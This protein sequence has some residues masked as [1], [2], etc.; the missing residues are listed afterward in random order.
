V[1]RAQRR[2]ER[3]FVAMV[4]ADLSDEPLRIGGRGRQ[5]LR[6]LIDLERS[7]N[8]LLLVA[9]VEPLEEIL[10]QADQVG[11]AHTTLID[12]DARPLIGA[13]EVG[14]VLPE[15]MRRQAQ[16]QR[17]SS[18][19]GR[20]E[21]LGGEEIVAAFVP[22]EGTRWS[23]VSR[24]PRLAADAARRR[25]QLA[26]ASA[27]VGALFIATLLSVLGYRLLVRPI[28]RLVRAQAEVAGV[29]TLPGGSEIA[30]LESTFAQLLRVEQERDSIGEVF[31]GR[32]R[33]TGKLGRGGS[34]T[35]FKGFD[36]VLQRPVALK[37]VPL[38]NA[39]Q[40][41]ESVVSKLQAEAV[42]LARLNHPHIVTV[43][44]FERKG[45]TAYIAM[46][47][48][49]GVSLD[50]YLS[51][52]KSMP[53]R[54]GVGIA[55]AITAALVAAHGVN[56]VHG[57]LKPGNI[58]VGKDGAI[59]V[60]DFGTARLAGTNSSSGE[61]LHGTAGYLAP[62]VLMRHGATRVSDLFSLGVVIY[63]MFA[64]HRPFGGGSTFEI[65][66]RT[67]E[68]QPTDLAEIRAS[69]PRELTRL[70]MKLLAKDP[71]ERPNSAAMV[72]EVL[73]RLGSELGEDW[74]LDVEKVVLR[75]ARTS[76][77]GATEYLTQYLRGS[78]A[79]GA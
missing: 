30:Q 70:V 73:A 58:L 74:K 76:P 55:T 63:Q 3:E 38:A 40:E 79:R 34:G 31:L 45:D 20:Y 51:Q 36:P 37:V 68:S 60:A 4:L 23:V 15:F 48:I 32:Y 22:V 61:R 56:M 16:S 77:K 17:L 53:V 52:T 62:E 66:Q 64:G 7:G 41:V 11:E 46:E 13:P 33:V 5:W 47:R 78:Q 72:G 19:A 25:M 28:R 12:S 71:G 42:H 57:D 44:D 8:R 39:G 75:Q 49:D 27:T 65:L 21:G 18:G 6:L 9:G 50:H 10:L 59:K 26:T 24:Q 14:D 43:F 2:E 35:V 69:L 67:L 29:D 1:V 54:D